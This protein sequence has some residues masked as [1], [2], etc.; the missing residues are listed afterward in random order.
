MEGEEN[1]D[2]IKNERGCASLYARGAVGV[3]GGKG[4]GNE[5]KRELVCSGRQKKQMST[6]TQ[7][8]NRMRRAKVRMKGKC[9]YRPCPKRLKGR[10]GIYIVYAN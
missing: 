5:V 2:T 3:H 6:Q 7:A 8:S 1:K 9:K 4:E 10:G